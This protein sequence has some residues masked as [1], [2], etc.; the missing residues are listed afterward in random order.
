MPNFG[1]TYPVILSGFMNCATVKEVS[2]PIKLGPKL[3]EWA[4]KSVFNGTM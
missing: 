1:L 3:G 4:D 2:R